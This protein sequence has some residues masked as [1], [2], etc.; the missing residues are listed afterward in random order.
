MIDIKTLEAIKLIIEKADSQENCFDFS[1]LPQDEVKTFLASLNNL[2]KYLVNFV[3]PKLDK[4]EVQKWALIYLALH[5]L[6]HSEI[7][8]QDIAKL[9]IFTT[10]PIFHSTQNILSEEDL[11][12]ISFTYF[13]LGFSA[14]KINHSLDYLISEKLI[15]GEFVALGGIEKSIWGLKFKPEIM[16]SVAKNIQEKTEKDRHHFLL[17][18]YKNLV[19]DFLTT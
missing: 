12:K 3:S 17:K 10:A 7:N 8:H 5:N 1:F 14:L 4:N 18:K 11:V 19:F 16:P 6:W 9:E 13:L 2:P 15:L